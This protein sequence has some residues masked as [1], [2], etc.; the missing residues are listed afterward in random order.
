MQEKLEKSYLTLM[1]E[2]TF[3]TLL[4]QRWLLFFAKNAAN[5]HNAPLSVCQFLAKNLPTSVSYWQENSFSLSQWGSYSGSCLYRWVQRYC[6]KNNH[7]G[8]LS[9]QRPKILKL[10]PFVVLLSNDTIISMLRRQTF[11]LCKTFIQLFSLANDFCRIIKKVS[12][13]KNRESPKKP[14]FEVVKLKGSKNIKTKLVNVS[15]R[16]I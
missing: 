12:L 5:L 9:I 4:V 13:V 6:L 3:L 14:L 10:K 8:D 15:K 1:V 7:E 2:K 16:D 11:E